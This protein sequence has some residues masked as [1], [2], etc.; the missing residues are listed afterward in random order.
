MVAA[1]SLDKPDEIFPDSCHQTDLNQ[2]E[3]ISGSRLFTFARAR[4]KQS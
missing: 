3:D 2:A 4:D 1:N